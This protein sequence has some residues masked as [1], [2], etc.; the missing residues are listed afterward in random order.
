MCQHSFILSDYNTQICTH[1]GREIRSSLIPSQGYTENMPL[2]IG[3][4]RYNRM[5]ALLHQLFEP[6]KYGRANSQVVYEV[7]KQTFDNG[8][9]LLHWLSKQSIKNK[10]YQ[11]AHFYFAIHKPY[12]IPPP[13]CTQKIHGMLTLFSK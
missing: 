11:N 7:M 6:H 13:P 4:S 3:Y 8:R 2:E 9:E 12:I 10:R 1:C 5:Y